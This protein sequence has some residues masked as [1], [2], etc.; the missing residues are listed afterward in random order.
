MV[1][2]EIILAQVSRV[3]HGH[4]D[5]S[6]QGYDVGHTKFSLVSINSPLVCVDN[7][8]EGVQRSFHPQ[9]DWDG[10]MHSYNLLSL[11]YV[12]VRLLH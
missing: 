12:Y 11:K 9:V 10:K 1:N 3:L 2:S 8:G 5:T 6:G 7:S 4:N